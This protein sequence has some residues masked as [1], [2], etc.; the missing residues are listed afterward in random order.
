M[1]NDDILGGE[2]EVVDDIEMTCE[3]FEFTAEYLLDEYSRNLEYGGFLV[4]AIE[5]YAYAIKLRVR[6][7]KRDHG[8]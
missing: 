4:T 2:I 6:I 1:E 3:D 5:Y 8:A 7:I